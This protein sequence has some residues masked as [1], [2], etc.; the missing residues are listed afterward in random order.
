MSAIDERFSLEIQQLSNFSD[1][2]DPISFYVA[3]ATKQNMKFDLS[4]EII[5]NF[6]A[7][8]LSA[9]N[10]GE[11]S[12]AQRIEVESSMYR[13]I[14]G[15]AKT[16]FNSFKQANML[17]ILR[18]NRSSQIDFLELKLKEKQ[19]FTDSIEID[20]VKFLKNSLTGEL[21]SLAEAERIE[22]QNSELIRKLQSADSA[23]SQRLIDEDERIARELA[24]QYEIEDNQKPPEEDVLCKI[25]LDAIPE[26]EFMPLESCGDLF[27]LGCIS[28]HIKTQIN[29][30]QF[31]IM[32]PLPECKKEIHM[33]DITERLTPEDFAKYEDYTFNHFVQLNMDSMTCCPTPNCSYVFT[34]FGDV[35]QFLCPVCK[36]EYCLKC[37]CDYHHG[38]TCEEYKRE[39]IEE[40]LDKAFYDFVNGAKFKMC[41]KCRFW[42]EKNEGCDHMT[43]RCGNEFCYVCGGAYGNCACIGGMDIG[44][45]PRPVYLPYVSH[46][47]GRRARRRI[48]G[49]GFG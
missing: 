38:K 42:V 13:G 28:T 36:H 40:P 32:C 24:A 16:K 17:P 6:L 19:L 23:E 1:K 3:G 7:D 33:V 39:K 27:H 20:G 15:E 26:N 22:R 4:L 14:I 48:L 43:C 30:R 45:R 9:F 49:G 8:V 11:I 18:K 31:P 5:L 41:S 21:V 37:K 25:C 12:L 47:G 44:I 34:Y 2:L 29:D 35:F 10:A 46:R